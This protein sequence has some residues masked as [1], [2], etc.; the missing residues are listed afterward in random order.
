MLV[1]L[2]QEGQVEMCG[3]SVPP[4][5]AAAMVRAQFTEQYAEIA[6]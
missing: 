4:P 1:P 3:N 6:A 2:S 5:M